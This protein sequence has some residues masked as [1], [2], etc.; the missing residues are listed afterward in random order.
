MIPLL[1]CE[2]FLCVGDGV[3]FGYEVGMSRKWRWFSERRD[4]HYNPFQRI[5]QIDELVIRQIVNCILRRP[6]TGTRPE[7]ACIEVPYSGINEGIVRSLE[8]AID[9]SVIWNFAFCSQLTR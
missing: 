2:H 9:N 4:V 3:H 8:R 6:E 1:G 7:T 5:Y